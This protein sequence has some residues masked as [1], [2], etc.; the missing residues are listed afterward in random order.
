MKKLTILALAVM[1]T[2]CATLDDYYEDTIYKITEAECKL[3][4]SERWGRCMGEHYPNVEKDYSWKTKT[5]PY[6]VVPE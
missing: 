4:E 1:L 3:F 6:K 5:V 2:G